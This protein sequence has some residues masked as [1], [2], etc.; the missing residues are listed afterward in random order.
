MVPNP[1]VLNPTPFQHPLAARATR[2]ALRHTTHMSASAQGPQPPFPRPQLGLTSLP[3]VVEWLIATH[4][5]AGLLASADERGFAGEI[6]LTRARPAVDEVTA[7]LAAGRTGPVDREKQHRYVSRWYALRGQSR[8]T[9]ALPVDVVRSAVDA[10]SLN[11]AWAVELQ[12]LADVWAHAG[13]DSEIR[14]YDAKAVEAAIAVTRKELLSEGEATP[15]EVIAARRG[16]SSGK[17]ATR[18]RPRKPDSGSYRMFG[19]DDSLGSA[20]RHII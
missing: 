14:C 11:D 20:D 8:H 5:R 9:R 12:R 1:A 6:G 2:A 15:A 13:Q 18:G 17:A 19:A 10:L 7:I 3:E 16:S 4:C